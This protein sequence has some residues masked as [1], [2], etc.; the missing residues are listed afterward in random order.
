MWPFKRKRNSA[1]E[2]LKQ[3]YY[4]KEDFITLKILSKE[5]ETSMTRVAHDI[6]QVYLGYKY[7]DATGDIKRLQRDIDL[8]ADDCRKRRDELK[9]YKERFGSLPQAPG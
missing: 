2:N 7:G 1:R 8:V 5:G 6:L 3:V 4:Y 9:L